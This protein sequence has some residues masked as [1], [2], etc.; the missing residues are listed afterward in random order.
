M[1]KYSCEQCGK[2]FSKKSA[3]DS[4]SKRKTPCKNNVNKIKTLVDNKK[5]NDID[6]FNYLNKREVLRNM[7]DEEFEIFLPVFCEKLEKE[8]YVLTIYLT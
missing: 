2:E 6:I 8:S 5:Y 7:T 4:H 1:V 3:Y